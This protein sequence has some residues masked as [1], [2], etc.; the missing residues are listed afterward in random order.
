MKKI[1]CTLAQCL[2][3]TLFVLTLANGE[4]C[5]QPSIA[6]MSPHSHCGDEEDG[7]IGLSLS[8]HKKYTYIMFF[9]LCMLSDHEPVSVLINIFIPL[10][11]QRYLSILLVITL[12]MRELCHWS[13]KVG[14]SPQSYCGDEKDSRIVCIYCIYTV[15]IYLYICIYI[16]VYIYIYL[17]I[18]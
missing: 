9:A 5:H 6:G 7:R 16:Y 1:Q 13:S 4:L 18:C 17:Y 3:S 2:L 12:T 11:V 15:Y 14:M 8:R 10:L